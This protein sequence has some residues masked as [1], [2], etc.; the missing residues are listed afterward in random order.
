ML[1]V[2]ALYV[3]WRTAIA[4]R[5]CAG[6]ARTVATGKCPSIAANGTR[7]AVAHGQLSFGL[8]E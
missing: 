5:R 2:P 8:F 1:P 4:A 3:F 6:V 7:V